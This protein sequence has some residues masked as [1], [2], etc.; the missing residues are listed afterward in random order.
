[1]LER[2]LRLEN[3]KAGRFLSGIRPPFFVKFQRERGTGDMKKWKKQICLLL[4]LFVTCMNIYMGDG[5]LAYAQNIRN[6]EIEPY[7]EVYVIDDA[8]GLNGGTYE[9][10]EYCKIAYSDNWGS[11]NNHE[12][13]AAGHYKNT[14]S[15]SDTAGAVCTITFTG[16]NLKFY[17]QKKAYST[18]A[19]ASFSLDGGEG[20]E[21]SFDGGNQTLYQQFLY[22]TGVLPFGTHVL[23]ITVQGLTIIDRVEVSCFKRA[24]D[25]ENAEKTASG[26]NDLFRFQYSGNWQTTTNVAG[27]YREN[28][29]WSDDSSAYLEFEFTGTSLK[30]YTQKASHLGKALFSVDGGEETLVDLYSSQEENQ[31]LVYEAGNLGQGRHKLKVQVT[32]EKNESSIGCYVV[33]DRIDVYE[34]NCSHAEPMKI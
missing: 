22:D 28:N 14:D 11:G 12:G 2:K 1:M 3:K 13:N 26:D 24:D 9:G 6:E 31:V 33:A 20:R 25:S 18:N 34:T 23:T 27:C 29:H 15:W 30:Y 7:D 5:T 19:K 4:S 10:Q 17:S 32:G 21:V 8:D 16:T